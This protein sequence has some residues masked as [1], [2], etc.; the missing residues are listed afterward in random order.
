[1]VGARATPLTLRAAAGIAQTVAWL[2]R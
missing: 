2:V 1:V